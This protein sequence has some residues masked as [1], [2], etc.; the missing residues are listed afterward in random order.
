MVAV[1]KSG[2]HISNT[3]I[4]MLTGLSRLSHVYAGTV[5]YKTVQQRRKKNRAAKR[6]R[7][8]NRR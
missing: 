6:S 8:I 5:P 7:K 1:D 2:F 4:G 3:Y